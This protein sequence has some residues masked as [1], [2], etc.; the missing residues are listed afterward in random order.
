MCFDFPSGIWQ[1][2]NTHTHIHYYRQDTHTHTCTLTQARNTHTHTHTNTGRT[3][4][5]SP[6][7][8]CSA[9]RADPPLS[10]ISP[11]L[12]SPTSCPFTPFFYPLT[13]ILSGWPSDSAGYWKHFLE[14]LKNSLVRWEEE[15]GVGT[16]QDRQTCGFLCVSVC[17]CRCRESCRSSSSSEYTRPVH[18]VSISH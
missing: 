14:S 3:H 7:R 1:D 17:V 16:G 5:G 9:T 6:A 8:L 11:P 15:G 18:Q 2:T 4:T 12:L 13:T 10:G